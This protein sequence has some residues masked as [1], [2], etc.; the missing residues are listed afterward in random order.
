[1][2]TDKTVAEF[3]LLGAIN[4]TFKFPR[5]DMATVK[6]MRLDLSG[7][8][9]A[10]STGLRHWLKWLDTMAEKGIKIVY[11]RCPPFIIEQINTLEKLLPDDAVIESLFVPYYCESCD[12][13][14]DVLY[15]R[16]QWIFLQQTPQKCRKCQ[17][18]MELSI[19]EKMYFAFNRRKKGSAA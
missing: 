16:E 6:T 8:S 3:H 11:V 7:V 1:M 5:P 9:Y 18:A 2:A 4:E 17:K 12:F 15:P 13:E 14:Q 19:Q 10:N